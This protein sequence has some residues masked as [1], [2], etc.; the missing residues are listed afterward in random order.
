MKPDEAKKL[1]KELGVILLQYTEML[2]IDIVTEILFPVID[3][4]TD[5]PEENEEIPVLKVQITEDGSPYMID[6]LYCES[7]WH[8]IYA[9]AASFPECEYVTCDPSGE[10]N[11][12]QKLPLCNDEYWGNGVCLWQ[13]IIPA[14][15]VPSDC[16]KTIVKIEHV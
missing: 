3:Q 8:A 12:W 5:E 9:I 13:C 14:T 1:K 11:Y 2:G 10:I 4:F 6:N 7:W 15:F 16:S